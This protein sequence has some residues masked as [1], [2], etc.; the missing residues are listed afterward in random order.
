MSEGGEPDKKRV[1]GSAPRG[2]T[3]NGRAGNFTNSSSPA[4]L[5][6]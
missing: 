4:I 6:A 5:S 1:K 2:E 3:S